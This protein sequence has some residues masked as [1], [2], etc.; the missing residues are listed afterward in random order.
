MQA[1]PL[2]KGN[3]GSQPNEDENNDEGDQD[4]VHYVRK[5]S[6]GGL[7]IEQYVCLSGEK[8]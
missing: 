3:Q 5:I 2:W 6:A 1:M 7:H 8:Y 4:D